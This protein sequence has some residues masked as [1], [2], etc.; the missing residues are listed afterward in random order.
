M[1]EPIST[2]LCSFQGLSAVKGGLCFGQRLYSYYR[3]LVSGNSVFIEFYAGIG[4]RV[5][6]RI[7]Y[8]FMEL[9]LF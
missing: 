3:A 4:E 8:D 2:Q 5:R 9:W 7:G 1:H 6:L